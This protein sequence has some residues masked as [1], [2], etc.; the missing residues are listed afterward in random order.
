M[1]YP[2]SI[3]GIYFCLSLGK[4]FNKIN[5]VKTFMC[6]I[7]KNSFHIMALHFLSIKIVDIIYSKINNINDINKISRFPNSYSN[8]LWIIY[9]LMGTCLP[10]L[11][12]FFIDKIKQYVESK[13]ECKKNERVTI[14]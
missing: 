10:I 12:V 13:K 8:K 14:S 5:F 1:F 3:I 9:V 4:M 2:I 6:Y 7:G 11:L